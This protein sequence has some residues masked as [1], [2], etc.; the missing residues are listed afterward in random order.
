MGY[1]GALYAHYLSFVLPADFYLV[2]T[3]AIVAPLIIGGMKSLTG[4]VVG[5]VFV[6]GI[7]EF[8]RRLETN[9]IG[10]IDPGALSGYAPL[11]VAVVFL[12]ILI[13]RPR[14]LS[15]GKELPLP[16]DWRRPRVHRQGTLA[17]ERPGGGVE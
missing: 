16:S 1:G 7:N 14:G 6:T 11:V 3:F 9:G 12:A 17:T 8:M 15:A 13:S 4:A 2:A 10:P 5:I